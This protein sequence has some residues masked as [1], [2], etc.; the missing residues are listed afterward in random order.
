[1]STEPDLPLP[2][3]RN[4]LPLLGETLAFLK[5]GYAFIEDRRARH[6]PVFRT[7]LLGRPTAVISGPDACREWIDP[8]KIHRSGA[9]P[10]HVERL[11][12][13]P[14]LPL[15]DG[16]QHRARKAQVLAGFASRA[17]PGYLA[18]LEPLVRATLERWAAAPEIGAVEETK[19]LA[20]EGICRNVLGLEPGPVT[21]A[22]RTDYGII[23]RGFTAL[24]VNLPGTRFRKALA[25]RDRIFAVYDRLIRE[26]RA[27]PRDDALA[28]ILE[29]TGPDGAR[30]S[31]A[32]ARL[33][34][35]HVV[36]AGYIV[37]AELVAAV[38]HLDANPA[39]LAR[40]RDELR[41]GLRGAPTVEGLHAL[42]LLRCVV[43]EV[44][45][46]CPI[47]PAVFGK[48]RST[49]T[50]KG[51]SI[52]EGWMVLWALRATQ[53]DADVYTDP[54]VFDPERFAPGRAED[55]RH[56]FAFTPHGPGTYDGHKCPGTDYA[57]LFMELFLAL[58]VRDHA[59]EIPRQDTAYDRSKTPP[60]PK[61]GLRLRVR[62][63]AP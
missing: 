59:W 32:E 20:L 6:G 35:H 52:P 51:H 36:V 34:L 4:G 43:M 60:E 50:F 17:L 22:L 33:E 16:A 30:I 49:F 1:M 56:E 14:S 8:A 31:D 53:T 63:T 19:R 40:L 54:L 46:L 11:F 5:D 38:L 26:H 48:A 28:R 3:G 23:T 47:L 25:A 58:L 45:R 12:G 10:G 9:M 15:L 24:P 39:V 57:T 13:G 62:R 21:D 41:A 2:P 7:R 27:A 29:A 42:P 61:D 55:R 37:Y 18:Q 44:K